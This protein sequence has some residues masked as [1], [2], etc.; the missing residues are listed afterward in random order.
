MGLTNFPNGI[1][2]FGIPVFGTVPATGGNVYFVDY[3]KGSDANT[4]KSISKP[5]KT[6]AKAY[7]VCTTDNDDVIVLVGSAAH[8]LT[9]MLTVSKNRIHFIGIDGTSGRMYGQNAKIQI[10]VTTAT[11][12]VAAV[13]VTGIRNSFTNIKF[14]SNNTLTQA[15]YTVLEAGEYTAYTC[16][17]FYKSTH[18]D[19]TGAA[20]FV[21]NGDSTQ[22]VNCT[23]G[24]LADQTVG[25]VI[26]PTVLCTGGISTGAKLRDNSFIGCQFWRK[27]GNAAARMIYGANA[28]DVERLLLFKGCSFISNALGSAT[29]GAAVTFGAAQTQGTVLVQDCTSVDCTLMV[30]AAVGIYVSGAVPTFATTG[31]AVAS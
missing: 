22:C 11:T 31:V 7:D 10:G 2:S 23:F 30:T 26:R 15:A 21:A 14:I 19:V 13:K 24:S 3:T 25:A 16:C 29:P 12:D 20:E 8:V 4:G 27:A 5:F 1:S 18:L 9:E 17:E 6:V 28:T